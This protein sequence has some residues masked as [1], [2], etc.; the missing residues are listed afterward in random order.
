MAE[1][2]ETTHQRLKKRLNQALEWLQEDPSHT[3]NAA[4]AQFQLK[5]RL[6]TSTVMSNGRWE[7]EQHHPLYMLQFATSNSRKNAVNH[8]SP[9]STNGLKRIRLFIRLRQS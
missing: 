2:T 5:R 1:I 8:Q 4:E 7:L 9:S 3:T 6:F